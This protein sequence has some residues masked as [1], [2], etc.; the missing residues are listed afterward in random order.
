LEIARIFGLVG[1]RPM[2]V[3]VVEPRSSVVPHCMSQG[4]VMDRARI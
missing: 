2:R 4:L 1:R 3:I